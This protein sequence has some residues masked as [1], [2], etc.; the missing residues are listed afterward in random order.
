MNAIEKLKNNPKIAYV[1]DER[2]IGN[3]IIITLMDGYCWE[4]DTSTGTMGFDNV[5]E[6]QWEVANMI[7]QL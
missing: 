3:G 6:A 2:Y 7:K 4:N 5:R 1:D